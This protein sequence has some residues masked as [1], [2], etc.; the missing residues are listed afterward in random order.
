MLN[1]VYDQPQ[2]PC[3]SMLTPAAMSKSTSAHALDTII[4]SI[5][6]KIVASPDKNWDLLI[7]STMEIEMSMRYATFGGIS[8]KDLQNSILL[9]NNRLESVV[10]TVE[11]DEGEVNDLFDEIVC[12]YNPRITQDAPGYFEAVVEEASLLMRPSFRVEDEDCTIVL[13]THC[14]EEKMELEDGEVEVDTEDISLSIRFSE[15]IVF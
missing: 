13:E 4:D 9:A 2:Q 12:E 11:G 15:N 3:H 5:V 7:R 8:K 10:F 1:L 6:K 14:D